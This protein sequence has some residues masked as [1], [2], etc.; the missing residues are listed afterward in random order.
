MYLPA[1]FREDRLDVMQDLIRAHPL[2]SLVTWDEQGLSASP[3][4][5]MVY[6]EEGRQGVLR[7]HMAKSNPHWKTLANVSECLIIFMGEQGYITPSWYQSKQTTHKVVPTWNY[8]TVHVW[9]KPEII[10]DGAWLYR[11]LSDLTNTQEQHR[12]QPWAIQD[13]PE[14]YIEAQMKAI[15]GIQI[16]ITRIEGKW[17]MSQNRA[18][19]DQQGVVAGMQKG[20]DPHHHLPLAKE[21]KA[22]KC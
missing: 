21:I 16:P 12:P 2:G 9:G 19:E 15:V 5:F 18:E 8:A 10:E 14:A 17:K 7:A 11:Q 4:P 20:E 1:S 22:R 3:I 6:P 13:A